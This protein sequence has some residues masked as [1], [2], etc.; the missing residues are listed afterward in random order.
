MQGQQLIRNLKEITE[1]G[2]ELEDDQWEEINQFL[3]SVAPLWPFWKQEALIQGVCTEKL[4]FLE[5]AI[6]GLTDLACSFR[7]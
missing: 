3:Q 7:Q 6:K 5:K 2:D 1:L 4:D